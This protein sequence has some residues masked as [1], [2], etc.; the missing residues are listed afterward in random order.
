MM[1]I[2]FVIKI[3]V[4]EFKYLTFIDQEPVGRINPGSRC[5][6]ELSLELLCM[7]VLESVY[8]GFIY[9]CGVLN[10]GGFFRGGCWFWCGHS[11]CC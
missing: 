10:G 1:L 7:L 6:I 4:H 5:R 9:V 3:K 2:K 11:G 8:H